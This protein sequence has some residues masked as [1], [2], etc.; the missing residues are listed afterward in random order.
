MTTLDRTAAKDGLAAVL[1]RARRTASTVEDGFPFVADPETGVWTTLTT[2]GHWA[3]GHWIG[4]LWTGAAHADDRAARQQFASAARS[5]TAATEWDRYVGTL[6]GGMN[7]LFGGFRA[8]DVT[9][10][11]TDLDRGLRG[12]D[13]MARLF[14]SRARVVPVGSFETRGTK[15]ELDDEADEPG[16]GED[17]TAVDAVHTAIPILL[18]AS[19]VTERGAYRAIA[20]DH[21]ERHVEWFLREDG[22]VWHKAAYDRTSGRVTRRYNQLAFSDETCWARGLGWSVAGLATAYRY[23]GERRYLDA[24]AANVDYYRDR[25]PD[26]HV[27]YWD[28]EDPAIPDAPRDTSAAALVAYGLLG[29]PTDSDRAPD[30]RTYGEHVLGSLVATYL[31]DDDADHRYG[32]ITH[33]CYNNVTGYATDNELIWTAYYVARSLVRWLNAP[34]GREPLLG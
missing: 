13:A 4:L 26:D 9:G 31:V 15:D 16:A 28:F 6:F 27:P 34:E 1:E 7:F 30:L 5:A 19:E 21:V 2:R 18:R 29:V 10:E 14:D 3:V 23:T 25:T 8:H 17:V 11:R 22:S 33:G 12:A 20:R 24:L 32:M